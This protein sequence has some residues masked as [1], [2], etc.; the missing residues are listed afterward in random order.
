MTNLSNM[1]LAGLLKDSP[2]LWIITGVLVCIFWNCLR[3]FF[4]SSRPTSDTHPVF[5]D[6]FPSN[7]LH[8]GSASLEKIPETLLQQL[9]SGEMKPL[10]SRALT[11]K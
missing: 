3:A 11:K 6:E 8:V 1:S 5:R 2:A 7:A 4:L 10:P 9:K